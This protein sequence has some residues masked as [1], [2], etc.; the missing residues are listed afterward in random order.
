LP[1]FLAHSAWGHECA[2]RTGLRDGASTPE[3]CKSRNGG[4]TRQAS[5]Q[6]SRSVL[7]MH[8]VAQCHFLP[9][10]LNG[11]KSQKHGRERAVALAPTSGWPSSARIRYPA[12]CTSKGWLNCVGL[13]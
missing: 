9:L 10:T 12:V 2:W 11:G 4:G 8:P 1:A 13:K 5:T 6:F 7:R 3:S